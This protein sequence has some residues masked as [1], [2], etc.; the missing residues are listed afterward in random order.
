ML[1]RVIELTQKIG[2][3]I[4]QKKEF[5]TK[6]GVW[7]GTQLKTAADNFANDFLS[8]ELIKIKELP[9]LSEEEEDSHG[10]FHDE[11]WI[12]DPID[13]TASLAEGYPGWV[14]QVA[15]MRDTQIILSVVH[16]PDLDLTYSAEV[17]K[18]A[19]LNGEKISI[20]RISEE[21]VLIDNY[22]KPRNITLDIFNNLNYTNYI[23]CGSIG[24]KICKVAQGEANLFFK[25]VKVRDWDI[26]PPLLIL[27]EAGG[28]LTNLDGSEYNSVRS[29]EKKGIIA[30][31]SSK[32]LMEVVD[33]LKM[34][35]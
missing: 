21:K 32:Y 28:L 33:F 35:K 12:I 29:I 13:G 6:E 18:G 30:S 25:D 15:L 20:T 5:Y 16:A 2:R 27:S 3:E 19:F 34:Q 8:K 23:E 17:G 7:Q 14:V 1:D 4:R 9:I 11:Y 26:L 24:L 10:S 22:P 31:T